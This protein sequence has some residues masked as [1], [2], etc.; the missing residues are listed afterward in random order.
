MYLSTIVAISAAYQSMPPLP[1]CPSE[2][3]EHWISYASYDLPSVP[4]TLT[5][6]GWR[7]RDAEAQAI[8]G[9]IV[10]MD[11]IIR[12]V[13]QEGQ[14]RGVR[15]PKRSLPKGGWPLAHTRD[16]SRL[17]Q[18]K[19]KTGP[20]V[21]KKLGYEERQMRFSRCRAEAWFDV[22]LLREFVYMPSMQWWL[23]T[24]FGKTV[25]DR[26]WQLVNLRERLIPLENPR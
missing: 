26:L 6:E 25:W 15:P 13:Y 5:P 3:L 1:H 17:L 7:S 16:V 21:A 9:T 14:E 8:I 22:Q 19:D 2:E 24:D 12:Y 23:P 10:E 4:L 18:H 11:G 20:E